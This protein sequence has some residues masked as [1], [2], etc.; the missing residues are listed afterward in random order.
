[1][2][3]PKAPPPKSWPGQGSSRTT[4]APSV[5]FHYRTFVPT[6]SVSAPVPRIGTLALA[7]ASD[8]SFSLLIGT[9]GSHVPHQSQIHV[10]A[11]SMPDADR[12]LNRLRLD[13][14]PQPPHCRG[15]DVVLGLSTRH[16]RFTFVRLHWIAPDAVIA[17]P[18]PATLTTKALY[19]S[20]LQW[21]E[22]SSCKP[23]SEGPPPSSVKHRRW[24]ALP[25][26]CSTGSFVRD[27]LK[28]NPSFKLSPNGVARGPGR[29]SAVHFRHP[30]P[31]VTPLVPA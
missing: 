21:F 8:L 26:F 24:C 28:P 22:I 30:G 11:A 7:G 23:T 18:F 5:Q 4:D 13:L 2:L 10:H 16:R 9:T 19:P 15:F 25:P 31:R 12:A 27:T 3:A 14:I 29:R 6:T 17:A 20:S 1:M